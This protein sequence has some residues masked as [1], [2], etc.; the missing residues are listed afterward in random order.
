MF[1]SLPWLLA[2][3]LN[4]QFCLAAEWYE[5][6]TL[7]KA[8]LIEWRAATNSNRLATAADI[9]YTLLSRKVVVT[10]PQQIR[11]FAKELEKCVSGV[12][13]EPAGWDLSLK[14]AEIAGMCAILMGWI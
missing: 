10:S 2:I 4:A 14:V 9:A 7:H 1:R 6:G 5:G 11:S 3:L 8:T 13:D 12:A